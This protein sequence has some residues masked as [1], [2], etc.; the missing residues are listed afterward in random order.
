MKKS[1]LILDFGKVLA[2][3]CGE[4]WF[5]TPN[6][7]TV[8]DMNLVNQKALMA[9]FGHYPEILD[10]NMKTEEDEYQNF[11]EFYR[12]VLVEIQYPHIME[13]MVAALAADFT[14][15]DEKYILYE[16]VVTALQK[17]SDRYQLLLLSDNWPSVLRVMR[18]NQIDSYFR[19]IYVSSQ[20]GCKKE[21]KIFFDYPIQEF[22]IS[23]NEAIFV[24]DNPMLLRIA[25]EKGLQSILMDRT[26]QIKCSDFPIIT[27]LT[28]I[29]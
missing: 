12:N 18:Y 22:N 21:E 8:V 10:R 4:H 3:P 9:S 20:Y 5:L 24:D 26:N 13:D 6:F 25:K 1:Y 11:K 28:Q 19:K 17:L 15:N 23:A 16:D 2:G 14:W 7:E 29:P 27:D